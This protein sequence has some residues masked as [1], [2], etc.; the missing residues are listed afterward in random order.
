MVLF[1]SEGEGLSTGA[2]DMPGDNIAPEE[3]VLQEQIALELTTNPLHQIS[4][5][6]LD[7][8]LDGRSH[9]VRFGINVGD[10]LASFTVLDIIQH[11]KHGSDSITT[12][13]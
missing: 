1:P 9:D 8:L 7:E 13:R 3:M 2:I 11:R 10:C 5:L 4:G 12:V 6:F